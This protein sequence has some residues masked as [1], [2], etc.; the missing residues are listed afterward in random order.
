MGSTIVKQLEKV[1]ITGIGTIQVQGQT[2]NNWTDSTNKLQGNWLSDG[3]DADLKKQ[4]Q[5]MADK[6]KAGKLDFDE[7]DDFIQA[8]MGADFKSSD[9]SDQMMTTLMNAVGGAN[10]KGS[11]KQQKKSAD[12]QQVNSMLNLINAESSKET[13]GGQAEVKSETSVEQQNTSAMQPVQDAGDSWIQYTG[14]L[15]QIMQKSYF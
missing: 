7:V 13:S 15:S 10:A 2:L 12:L 14:L 9:W 5:E 1:L 4:I 11:D 8:H 6:A 3:G